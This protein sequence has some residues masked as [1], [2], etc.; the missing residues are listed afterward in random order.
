M[1]RNLVTFSILI[2]TVFFLASLPLSIVVSG[3]SLHINWAVAF[4]HISMFFKGVLSGKTFTYVEGEDRIQSFFADIPSH[5]VT[6]FLYLLIASLI[7]ISFSLVLSIWV[8]LTQKE[9][10]KDIIGLLS[11]IPDFIM[12]IFLQ[13]F[14]VYIYEEYGIALSR[15]ATRSSTEPAILLP[16]MVMVLIPLIYLIRSLSERSFDIMTEDY[17]LSAKSKGIKKL[18][19]IIHHVI[20]NILPFLKADLHKVLAIMMSNLFI[21]EYLFNI[22]GLS[23]FIFNSY[24]YQFN[25]TV[26]TLFSLTIVYMLL[27]FCLIIFIKFLERVFAND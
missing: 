12:I 25:L 23:A 9:W 2:L 19:I 8:S 27:Y 5:F 17:I 4:E 15:V 16:L 10:I 18:H 13:I 20:R 1:Y 26:N 22:N 14:V 6:S 3:G 24:S 21:V 7:A 11:V